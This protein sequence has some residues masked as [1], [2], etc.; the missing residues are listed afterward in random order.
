VTRRSLL[1]FEHA[2]KVPPQGRLCG[3][4]SHPP[5]ADNDDNYR[6]VI[7]EV[8]INISITTQ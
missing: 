6:V 8:V 7:G 2:S 1:V 3:P 5:L 4:F